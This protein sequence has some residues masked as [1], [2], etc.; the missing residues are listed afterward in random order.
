[1][2]CTSVPLRETDR[3]TDRQ[4]DR[5]VLNILGGCPRVREWVEI[6]PRGL[7]LKSLCER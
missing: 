6:V 1:M 7:G 3:Q 2:A 4:T 5:E